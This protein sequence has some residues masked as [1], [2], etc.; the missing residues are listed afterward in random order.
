MV[1]VLVSIAHLTFWTALATKKKSIST[2]VIAVSK[3]LTPIMVV[4]ALKEIC[5]EPFTTFS[6]SKSLSALGWPDEGRPS[7]VSWDLCRRTTGPDR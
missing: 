2:L 7:P 6:S 3:F 1:K 4:V 5:Y